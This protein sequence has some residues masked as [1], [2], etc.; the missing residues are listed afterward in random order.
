M[1]YVLLMTANNGEKVKLICESMKEA[2]SMKQAFMLMGQY[3]DAEIV[4]NLEAPN[5]NQ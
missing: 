2:Q 1:N 5:E 3:R 4:K